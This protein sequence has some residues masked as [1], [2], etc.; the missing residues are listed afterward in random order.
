MLAEVVAKVGETQRPFATRRSRARRG[1]I[2]PKA[3]RV[4]DSAVQAQHQGQRQS[5]RQRVERETSLKT[6]AARRPRWRVVD[7]VGKT[8]Q[9]VMRA[10]VAGT[11][12]CE[13]VRQMNRAR[14]Q[15]QG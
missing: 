4:G 7:P 12:A 9:I 11:P 5:K 8:L 15:Q 3:D 14:V 2:E 6:F 1:R 10:P 13:V